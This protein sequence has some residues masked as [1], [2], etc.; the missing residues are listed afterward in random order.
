MTFSKT[1][2]W[3]KD[4][5]EKGPVHET[6]IQLLIDRGIAAVASENVTGNKENV[7]TA[8][9]AATKIIDH[10]VSTIQSFKFIAYDSGKYGT[11]SSSRKRQRQDDDIT[12]TINHSNR[13]RVQSTGTNS[14]P[15][16]AQMNHSHEVDDAAGILTNMSNGLAV[17]SDG[18]ERVMRHNS[19]NETQSH[20]ANPL[21]D[22][23]VQA[24]YAQIPVAPNDSECIHNQNTMNE[25]GNNAER[26]SIIAQ[27]SANF[28]QNLSQKN[29]TDFNLDNMI[30]DTTLP[31]GY[32]APNVSSIF[33]NGE[34]IDFNV[35]DMLSQLPRAEF[36]AGTAH[37]SDATSTRN[38]I[39][40]FNLDAMPSLR[41]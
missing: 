1:T 10:L 22:P 19:H 39:A 36:E 17:G 37:Q 5:P 26:G 35:D 7:I 32:S 29:F 3:E 25:G 2:R 21:F 27:P 14:T 4:L 13:V 34:Y 16:V 41:L 33:F 28:E 18:S 12:A 8:N 6:C 15:D 31:D 30:T 11:E 23:N 9:T 38:N 40:D 24:N 20:P